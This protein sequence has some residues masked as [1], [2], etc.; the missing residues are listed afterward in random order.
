MKIVVKKENAIKKMFK[1]VSLDS[2]SLGEKSQV[3]KMNYVEGNYASPHKHPH[4]QSGYVI[5]GRYEL[6]FDNEKYELTEGDTY[7]IPENTL[8][9]FKVIEAG[10]VID[11]FTP[12]RKDY[13]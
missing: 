12:P 10:N 3:T 2:L 9:S 7:S 5:S 4:E 1:G 8:H 11:V 13:I 6:T